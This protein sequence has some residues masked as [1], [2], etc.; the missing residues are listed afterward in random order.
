LKAGRENVYYC[1][2]DSLIVNEKGLLN[3]K[4]LIDK[5]KLGF[6]KVEGESVNNFFIKPK[7]YI[8]DGKEII[9]GVKKSSIRLY[10]GEK[11]LIILSEQFE[12]FNSALRNGTID[13]QRVKKVN[14]VISKLYDKGHIVDG[15]I[16]PYF[17]DE[18]RET[19]KDCLSYRQEWNRYGKL[20]EMLVDS[21][22]VDSSLEKGG[23]ND[24]YLDLRI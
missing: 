20:Q 14:K 4:D 7:Y 9:K 6:L 11:E 18:L 13:R 5:D 15:C 19:A 21:A 12:R 1:D 8:F 10:D 23:E 3:L 24:H 2:T 22:W 17:L 16:V